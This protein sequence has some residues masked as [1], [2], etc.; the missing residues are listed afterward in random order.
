MSFN[1]L[2]IEP[3]KADQV[4]L[5]TYLEK[6][7]IEFS[8][9]DVIESWEKGLNYL[10]SHN[11]NFILFSSSS[12]KPDGLKKLKQYESV[13]EG[14]CLILF[15]NSS[16]LPIYEE[17][18]ELGVQDV[19]EKS[20]LDALRLE[21]SLKLSLE[22]TKI[23]HQKTKVHRSLLAK[24]ERLQLINE[25]PKVYVLR[26]DLEGRYTYYNNAFAR[27]FLHRNQ[28][29]IGEFSLLHILEEDHQ[30]TFEIVKQCMNN[31]GEVFRVNL[32]KPGYLPGTVVKTT[33]EFIGLTD[34]NGDLKEIQCTGF[35]LNQ[36]VN[37]QIEIQTG[38]NFQKKI[39]NSKHTLFLITNA[40]GIIK[41]ASGSCHTLMG[42]DSDSL[43]DQD[44]STLLSLSSRQQLA[45]L[46]RQADPKRTK[47]DLEFL[48]KGGE[49]LIVSFSI[50]FDNEYW[51]LIGR[52]ISFD[53]Q[54]QAS[55]ANQLKL[56]NEVCDSLTL[57]VLVMRTTDAQVLLA[58]SHL[59]KLLGYNQ[60]DL[61]NYDFND[62]AIWAD[63][64]ER[65]SY[66]ELLDSTAKV[67]SL[68]CTWLTKSGQKKNLIL[69]AY[70]EIINGD[71]SEVILA[72]DS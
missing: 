24:E 65:L 18:V 60:K 44:L 22:R 32:R 29:V 53:I 2:Y 10:Q 56:Y 55:K 47:I 59:L 41:H 57:G 51:V 50:D 21:R 17:A 72:K 3:N 8:N 70:L 33:W 48:G 16:Y 6:S 39:L 23:L 63:E 14:A 52:D 9:I 66:R 37:T 26:T 11:Y 69:D 4:L 34:G 35:D 68:A 28:S 19:I 42:L 31:P 45:A 64:S 62:K 46:Y 40:K 27:T 38:L 5:E 7:T 49:N 13:F 30:K 20:D 25:K 1:L 67:R 61:L 58:N 36:S 54:V 71:L 12:L 15:S 43:T